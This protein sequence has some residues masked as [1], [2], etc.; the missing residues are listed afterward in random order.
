MKRAFM[1][2]GQGSQRPGMGQDLYEQ[3]P[4][5]AEVLDRAERVRPGL[6]EMM[7]TGY[8]STDSE[9]SME[10]RQP[11]NDRQN[12][13]LE[14]SR[15]NPLPENDRQNL[16]PEL[17][18][19]QNTQPA[20]AAFAAGVTAVLY[21]AGIKPDYAAGLSLG[22]YSALHAAGVFD[23]DT[24]IGLTAFR[25]KVM[26]EAGAGKDTCMSAVLGLPAEA[27]QHICEAASPQGAVS[28]ANYNTPVQTVIAGYSSAVARAEALAKEAGA[29]RCIR[30]DV[31]SAFH[32]ELMNPASRA[33]HDYFN[34]IVFGNMQFPV[35]F[36]TTARPLA[37]ASGETIP[38]LLERQVK[39]SVQ[40]AGTI[41]YLADSGV[42][43]II[44]IGPGSA[45]SGFVRKTDKR[46]RAVSIDTAED[47]KK[48]LEQ[49]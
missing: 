30:L 3:F 33:L 13:F 8:S 31:S 34:N 32:T 17:S 20:L 35:I 41:R 6:K 10:K 39:S 43:E 14:N 12:R 2:A 16:M 18:Q 38:A 1:Y 7:F 5:F 24:L 4:L 46:I 45:I 22:E 15:Q 23:V 29:R 49:G 37:E 42:E 9:I 44:E 21:D 26:Q 19:T 11:E 28:V 36:N 27:V 48:V 47:L 40:M 25:G